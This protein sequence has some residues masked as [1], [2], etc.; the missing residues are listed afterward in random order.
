MLLWTCIVTILN[1]QVSWQ[2]FTGVFT[3]A[4]SIS[5]FMY[6]IVIV[7]IQTYVSYVLMHVT[8]YL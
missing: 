4:C 1:K 6:E 7:L 5:Y 8:I 2:L 3:L